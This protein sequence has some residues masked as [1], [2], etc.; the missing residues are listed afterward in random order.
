MQKLVVQIPFF[1]T[2]HLRINLGVSIP[3]RR[4]HTAT[5]QNLGVGNTQDFGIQKNSR[6]EILRGPGSICRWNSMFQTAKYH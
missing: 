5:V 3:H 4:L 2:E 6:L 1:G